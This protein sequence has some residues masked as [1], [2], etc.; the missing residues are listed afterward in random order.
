[1]KMLTW[2]TLRSHL[3]LRCNTIGDGEI[4]GK[5][6]SGMCLLAAG[7]TCPTWTYFI[8]TTYENFLL[9]ILQHAHT[10]A[11]LK[12]GGYGGV[13]IICSFGVS[14]EVVPAGEHLP[15]EGELSFITP[16]SSLICI[17][18]HPEETNKKK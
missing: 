13:L 4:S 1:M 17:T 7:M 15:A 10:H 6:T 12:A 8:Y 11:N 16:I 14:Y 2:S 3:S 5:L 18:S 9:K